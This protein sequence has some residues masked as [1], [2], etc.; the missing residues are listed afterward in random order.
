MKYSEKKACQKNSE[1]IET[2]ISRAGVAQLVEQLTCN[3]QVA[4]SSPIASSRQGGVPEWPKGTDCKSVGE[5]LRR[6]KSS[7]LHQPN[8]RRQDCCRRLTTEM[9]CGSSSMARASAFQA[10]GCGFESRFPLH[11][12]ISHVPRRYSS[13]FQNNLYIL[14]R[15]FNSGGSVYGEAEV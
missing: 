15:C 3:Q 8:S 1:P 11:S 7:P 12:H 9:P 14:A 13:D 2:T 6:F 10:E 4:G 5:R